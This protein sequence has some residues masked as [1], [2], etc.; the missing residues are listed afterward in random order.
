MSSPS[1]KD[2]P[3]VAFDLKNQLEGFNPD[4]MKKAD[5]NEKIILP[6]AEGIITYLIIQIINT[7]Y[8]SLF[9]FYIDR[10][11]CLYQFSVRLKPKP[12]KKN[13]Y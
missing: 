5:T 3:K 12:Y 8:Q 11:K 7:I 1:L 13:I 2:L 4:N 9:I 6:T 10:L